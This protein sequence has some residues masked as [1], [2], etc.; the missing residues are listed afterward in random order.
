M[1][2]FPPMPIYANAPITST[3]TPPK[4]AIQSIKPPPAVPKKPNIPATQQYD[5]PD[6]RLDRI[7]NALWHAEHANSVSDPDATWIRTKHAPKGGSVAFG[8][9]QITRKFM[10]GIIKNDPELY[11][12]HKDYIDNVLFPMQ[13]KF[14]EFGREPNKKGYDPRWDYGGYGIKHTPEMKEAY[15]RLGLDVIRYTINEER[16]RNK[17]FDP[18][19]N[20]KDLEYLVRLHRFG[21]PN[22]PT[23][24]DKPYLRRFI[25]RY[26]EYVQK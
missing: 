24:H 16:R 15:R 1:P 23:S 12:R 2:I 9:L 10:D 5:I 13:L 20:P 8:P 22:A 26:N 25:K 17:N 18:V 11:K 6:A 21:A 19:K 7:Y 3:P 14:K 4:K